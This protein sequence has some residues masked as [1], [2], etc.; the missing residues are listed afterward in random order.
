MPNTID[1][2]ERDRDLLIELAGRQGVTLTAMIG[3]ALRRFKASEENNRMLRKFRERE[4]CK[5]GNG[6]VDDV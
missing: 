6:N 1:M 3:I 5:E 2:P 4:R